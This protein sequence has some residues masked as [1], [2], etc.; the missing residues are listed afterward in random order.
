MGEVTIEFHGICTHFFNPIPG[1]PHRVVLPQADAF[2]PGLI[3]VD[4]VLTPYFLPAHLS[5]ISSSNGTFDF[6]IDGPGICGGLIGTGVRLHIANAIPSPNDT[7]ARSHPPLPSLTEFDP[8]YRYSPE[9]VLGGRARCYFDLPYERFEVRGKAG[10]ASFGVSKVTT[11]GPPIL[12]IEPFS[13]GE[14][15]DVPIGA[16]LTVSNTSISCKDASLDFL[17]HFLTAEG[18]IPTRLA[19]EPLGFDRMRSMPLHGKLK[20]AFEQL[21]DLGYPGKLQIDVRELEGWNYE[22][23]PSC[24]NSQWP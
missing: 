22:N 4:S 8:G 17:L 5:L 7:T 16:T 14:P 6:P 13:G 23:D 15:Q 18:G 9:V 1:I 24:S 2:R 12:R 21:L 10:H 20:E 19:M 3:D 11:D